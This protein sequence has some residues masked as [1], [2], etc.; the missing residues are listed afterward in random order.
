M[1][2]PIVENTPK[3]SH[4]KFKPGEFYRSLTTDNHFTKNY[5]YLCVQ[6]PSG[7]ALYLA[8]DEGKLCALGNGANTVFEEVV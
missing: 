5:M 1:K 4:F 8:D 7:Q 6:Y 2:Y 3:N